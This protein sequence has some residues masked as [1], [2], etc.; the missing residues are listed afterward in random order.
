MNLNIL[1]DIMHQLTT[2]KAKD[3]SVEAIPNMLKGQAER[4]E[5]INQM[6][7]EELGSFIK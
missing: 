1:S 5:W 7:E 3:G 6:R 4:Y 2:F